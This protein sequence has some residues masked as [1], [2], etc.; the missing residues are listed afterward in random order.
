MATFSPENVQNLDT[1][2]GPEPWGKDVDGMGSRVPN[3][4]VE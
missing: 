4:Q 3:D 1:Y 2:V